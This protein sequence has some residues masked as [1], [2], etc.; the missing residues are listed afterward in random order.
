MIGEAQ[1]KAIL[2]RALG[3]SRAD[4][5]EALLLAGENNLTR[6]ANS[7]IHQ[8]VA[9]QNATLH[10][11][12]VLGK[13]IGQASTNDLGDAAVR[14]VVASAR[15]IARLQAENPDFVSLPAPA[16]LRAAPGYVART[17]SWTPE[18]RAR[19]VALICDRAKGAALN[20]A[21][22]CSAD[23]EE[24]AV[25]N[26]LG[27]LAY[28]A[29]TVAEISTVVMSAD[30]SGYAHRVA[31]D[32]GTID[33]AGLADEA[34]DKALR[35]RRPIA[36][37]PGD[38][39]VILEPY[40]V[41]DIVAFLADL[42]LNALAVK[43]QRSFMCGR[44]GQRLAGE[45]VSLYDDGLDPR[46]LPLPFDFEGVPKERVDFFTRGVATAVAYDSYLAFQEG[47]PST[48]H[49]LPSPIASGPLPLNMF[50]EGGSATPGELLSGVKRGLWVTRFWYTRPVEPLQATVTGMTRDGTFLVEN[51]ALAGPVKNLRFT[52]AYLEALNAVDGITRDTQLIHEGGMTFRV[53]TI[54]VRKWTFVS[55]TEY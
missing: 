50:M 34:V 15:D 8:N 54:K 37:P 35:G 51:G 24:I 28:H 27:I 18:E 36:V 12:A 46:G 31:L 19:A 17:A 47:K 48:G 41:Q 11:R 25:A 45:N 42:G 49:A 4:Q 44:F 16:P 53:P 29:R 6:F 3:Y 55:A 9:G 20:A 22:A 1:A 26:S 23:V 21:G 32:A 13:R 5:T 7:A 14:R 30:S 40:A 38:Y 52:Q 39:E 10:V 43:E 2:E 33:V